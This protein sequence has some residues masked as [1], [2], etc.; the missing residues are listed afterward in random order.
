MHYLHNARPVV[1]FIILRP[2]HLSQI[3]HHFE[4]VMINVVEGSSA[5]GHS[6][7]ASVIFWSSCNFLLNID[8]HAQIEVKL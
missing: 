8:T 1:S 2:P 6:G 5:H 3:Y 4:Y 7:L